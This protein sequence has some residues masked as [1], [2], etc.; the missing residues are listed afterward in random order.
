MATPHNAT[1]S[2]CSWVFTNGLAAKADAT[3]LTTLE[4]VVGVSQF[5]EDWKN[6]TAGPD[7]TIYRLW[8]YKLS[9]GALLALGPTSPV[10]DRKIPHAPERGVGRPPRNGPPPSE[11]EV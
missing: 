8:E 11:H 5:P 9:G 2:C 3:A 6:G 1:S 4:N 7:L 10:C